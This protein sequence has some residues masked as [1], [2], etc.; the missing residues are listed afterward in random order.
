MTSIAPEASHRTA[1]DG[2]CLGLVA[3]AQGEAMALGLALDLLNPPPLV[4]LLCSQVTAAH[5]AQKVALANLS[6]TRCGSVAFRDR[7]SHLRNLIV[8]HD[9]HEAACVIPALRDYL[10]RGYYD[11]L[12]SCYATT[13]LHTLLAVDYTPQLAYASA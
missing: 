1:L 9:E 5:A 11:Q 6:A 10:P 2:I 7:A 13:R 4:Y 3:H 8:H 12:A